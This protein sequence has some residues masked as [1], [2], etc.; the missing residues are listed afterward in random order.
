MKAI[1]ALLVGALAAS[2]SA[3]H[4]QPPHLRRSSGV[5][6]RASD[7]V[8]RAVDESL[9]VRA[10]DISTLFSRR[11]D[12]IVGEL[13]SATKV[14]DLLSSIT[15]EGQ[16]PTVNYTTGCDARRSNWPAADHWSNI[17]L[18]AGAWH[19]GISG[20]GASQ[21]VQDSNTLAAISKAMDWWFARD[22]TNLDCLDSGGTPKCPCSSTDTTM[23]NTNWFSSIILVPDLVGRA[24]LLVDKSLTPS[25]LTGC[26]NMTKRSYGAIAR[27]I[28]DLGIAD[29][30]NLLSI[31]SVGVDFGLLTNDAATITD[32]YSR[33]HTELSIQ[34][35]DKSNGIRQDGSFAQH[36]GMLYNGNYGKDFSNAFLDLE[37]E[38]AGTQFAANSGQQAILEQLFESDRWMIVRNTVTGV[39]HW[40]LSAIGRFISEPVAD[41]QASAEININVTEVG[42]LGKLWSSGTL[43][44]FSTALSGSGSN[45]NAGNLL[46]NRMYYDA[47][48]MVQRGSNYVSSVKMYSK[49]TQS[50]ECTNLQNAKGFHLSDGAVYTYLSGNEYEDIA[51]AW[52]WNLIPGITVDYNGTPLNCDNTAF[53][54]AQTFV[55]GVSTGTI[56]VA[57]MRYTNPSTHALRF[58]KAWFFLG[59][60]VQHVMV[61]N[62]STTG[63]APIYSVLDQKRHNGNILVDG[64][65]ASGS[66]TFPKAKTL[67]HDSVGY[68]FNPDSPVTLNVSVGT[69][70]GNWADIGIS[71][72]PGQPVDLFA[73][74]LVHSD[75]T[76]PIEYSAF[77]GVTSDALAGKI[78]GLQLQTITNDA[79]ISAVYDSKNSVAMGVFWDATGGSFKFTPSG[80]AGVTIAANAGATVIYDLNSG[81]LTV[82][83]P[84]H[85][86]QSVSVKVTVDASGT[87]PGNLANRDN[88]YSFD[89][90]AD[91]GASV[92]QNIAPNAPNAP[93]KQGTNKKNGAVRREIGALGFVAL[94][95]VLV[96]FI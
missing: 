8:L 70:T 35:A 34:T 31:A 39:L 42:A 11:I 92:I 48:Y 37:V 90:S 55:G 18:L 27:Q 47:D 89:L 30:A 86:T 69:K 28:N 78:S 83:D 96:L 15:S 3:S 12:T 58:Q 17:A 46:G 7:D 87:I 16:W 13:P 36:N 81:N 54:G 50:S 80:Q 71:T 21:F 32:A 49:R 66:N 29:G 52:D 85:T 1:L 77:P 24:C 56:G 26:T 33:S 5:I 2:V 23:W 93:G 67:W 63:T 65:A 20:S 4:P 57:A 9:L 91:P 43:N 94:A 53:P 6:S 22:F 76:T 60:D 51:A 10:D 14:P 62:L 44:D 74:F 25:Q 82:S 73:A 38:A 95:T 72:L 64:N 19:G 40:D 41:S 45:A 88:T 79:H 68:S 59:D 61:S 75:L 84:S